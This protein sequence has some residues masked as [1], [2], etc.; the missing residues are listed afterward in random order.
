MAAVFVADTS[1]MVAAICSW[2]E[3]HARAVAELERRFD[4]DER[5]VAVAPALVEAY[6]VLTRLPAPHRLSPSDAFRLLEA[7][8]MQTSPPVALDGRMYRTVLRRAP[9]DGI[10]GGQMYDA[11]IVECALKVRADTLITF[12]TRHFMPLAKGRINIV[13]PLASRS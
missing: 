9:G 6:A 2:H 3:H 8:F 11:V 10:A 13:P 7:N 12:N 4:R 5:F 1:C